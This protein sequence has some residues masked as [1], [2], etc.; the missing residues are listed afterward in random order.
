VQKSIGSKRDELVREKGELMD[1]AS[2]NLVTVG[3]L[4]VAVSILVVGFYRSRSYGKLGLF[5]WLQSVSLMT[6]WLTIFGLFSVGIYPNLVVIIL[7]ITTAAGLYIFFG[8]RL[9][10]IGQDPQQQAELEKRLRAKQNR[11]QN[12]SQNHNLAESSNAPNSP[13]GSN[14]SVETSQ[15][16]EATD[17][18][19]VS[20]EELQVMQSIFGID[21]FFATESV[22]YQ[23]GAF[24]KG[25]LRGDPESAYARLSEKLQ[26]RLGDRY[27]LFLVANTDGKPI[28][29][30]LPSR[31]DPK[32]LS[33]RQKIL[34]VVLAI[35]TAVTTL[36]TGGLLMG[37][38]L[39]QNLDRLPEV[40]PISVGIWVILLAREFGH[41]MMAQRHNVRLSWPFFLPTW[42]I[43]SFGAIDR[44][45]SLLPNRQI[46]F[47]IPFAGS[48][49]G[50]LLSLGM[51]L[52]GLFLSHSG[53]LFQIPADFFKA[54][55]LVGTLAKAILGSALEQPL[56]NVHPL[57]LVGWLGLVINAINLLPAGQLDGGRIVQA[58]YGREIAGRTTITTLILLTIGSIVN[59]IALYWAVLILF[60][61]RH[62]ERPSLNELVEPDDFR[63]ALALIALL[64]AIL[65]LIP[66]STRVA[67]S[68]GIGS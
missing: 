47:D 17:S 43:G 63:A 58:I 50:G 5:S 23:D 66:L 68:L 49:V 3:L 13:V 35:A 62:P 8:N 30:I 31:N 67:G 12:H 26:E 55:L 29:V 61:Q 27:R 11:S 60:L 57:A 44:F 21:T 2:E 14:S 15:P 24:F 42:Q 53:S 51:L 48:A 46:L 59:P 36:E 7:L 10:A 37:F 33:A 16:A 20:P 39:V 28:V 38:D 54:S 19:E 52:G 45:E 56:V 64:S 6:P 9:R 4:L 41:Q 22:P 18:M 25:N 34:A 32:P 1:I 65:T 40:L